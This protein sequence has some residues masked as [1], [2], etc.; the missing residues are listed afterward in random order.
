MYFEELKQALYLSNAYSIENLKNAYTYEEQAD[1]AEQKPEYSLVEIF[2]Q[3][4]KFGLCDSELMKPPPTIESLSKLPYKEISKLSDEEI[5]ELLKKIDARLKELEDEEKRLIERMSST[6]QAPQNSQRNSDKNDNEILEE[7]QKLAPK[8]SFTHAYKIRYIKTILWYFMDVYSKS[9]TCNEESLTNWRKSLAQ[10]TTINGIA[11][12]AC[13]VFEIISSDKRQDF[14]QVLKNRAILCKLQI[15]RNLREGVQ[16]TSF[17]SDDLVWLHFYGQVLS[18]VIAINSKQVRKLDSYEEEAISYI[19]YFLADDA[20]SLNQL[21]VFDTIFFAKKGLK[22]TDFS[23][24]QK[25]FNVL[26]V[27]AVDCGQKQLAYDTFFSW[28]NRYAVGELKDLVPPAYFQ[29]NNDMVWR[30][31][32][33]KEA[34]ANMRNNFAYVCGKICDTYE[35]NSERWKIFHSI[36]LDQALVAIRLAPKDSSYHCTYGTLL[37]ENEEHREALKHFELYR[38]YNRKL[39]VSLDS[40][41]IYCDTLLDILVESFAKR[42]EK[43]FSQWAEDEDT[44]GHFSNLHTHLKKYREFPPQENTEDKEMLKVQKSRKRWEPYFKLQKIVDEYYEEVPEILNLELLLALIRKT[45]NLLRGRLKRWEYNLTDYYTRKAQ[46][47]QGITG[48][49]QGIKPIAYYT[50]LN[51]IKFVFDDL[52]QETYSQAPRKIKGGENG[53]N[54]LTVMHAKYMNDPH[55]GLPLLRE[56]LTYIEKNENENILFPSN[57][58]VLFRESIHNSQFIF[59]KSFTERIDNLVMW[60]RYASDYEAD[61]KNS[62]GCCVQLDA[63]TFGQLVDPPNST[64]VSIKLENVPE[65]DYYLYRVVYISRDGTINETENPGL[66]PKVVQYYNTLQVLIYTLNHYFRELKEKIGGRGDNL[67]A[68]VREFLQQTLHTIIFLF[69]D[70]DYSDEVESR[71]IF[72]RTPD[73]QDEIRLLPTSP[74]KL[75]INPFFQVFFSQI[76]F[77]PNVR[78]QELWTPYLQ[79]QLNKMWRKHPSVSDKP[80]ASPNTRYSIENSK[81]HYHT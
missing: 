34:E 8:G 52:Y 51:T 81:I 17:A 16:K 67:I 60:N 49:R 79:Y 63:E 40:M 28:I 44:Q 72:V 73:Q 15:K 2:E 53:K 41:R 39:A 42:G 50:T 23:D 7:I 36:A 12:V 59:L 76:M 54:C 69:K 75:C 71:L 21:S 74:E 45:V 18:F 62:N 31:N 6:R 46:T 80:D 14:S 56:F 43:T 25:A 37:S 35:L 70:S 5:D 30:K 57:S 61:G 24:Q 4:E 68:Y 77:G 66:S 58:P 48:M 19:A 47:D 22:I 27:S 10:F 55:E 1:E 29:S 13:F 9:V 33:G 38:K 78:D 11:Q 64:A 65:D 26:G 32:E 3:L 20:I